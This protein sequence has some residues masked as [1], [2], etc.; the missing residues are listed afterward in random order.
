[1]RARAAGKFTDRESSDEAKD[2]AKPEHKIMP[3]LWHASIVA[4]YA[5]FIYLGEKFSVA[6]VPGE[7]AASVGGP[8][9]Y[10]PYLN[11][12]IQLLFFSLQLTAEAT[13]SKDLQRASSCIFTTVAFPI[14]A[15]II[16]IFWPLY[17]L[18]NNLIFPN[19]HIKVFPWYMKHFWSSTIILWNLL[20]VYFINHRFPSNATAIIATLLHNT[21]YDAWLLF[22]YYKNGRWA[23]P[24]LAQLSSL[25]ILAFLTSCKVMLF[26]MFCLEKKMASVFWGH[27]K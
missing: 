23:Y 2:P 25:Q 22:L 26:G 16:L 4:F 21:L 1:M 27:K 11:A 9:K 18:D 13:G 24:F 6:I 15:G 14:S 3:M 8:F 12:W 17:F 20:E 7:G 5:S 10:M 19:S